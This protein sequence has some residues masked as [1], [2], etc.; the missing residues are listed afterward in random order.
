MWLS[1][2]PHSAEPPRRAVSNESGG[3]G[4]FGRPTIEVLGAE[5]EMAK[6]TVRTL[7]DRKITATFLHFAAPL[8]HDPERGARTPSP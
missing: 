8:L 1:Q 2:S 5:G 4:Q 3:I 7:P 6:R